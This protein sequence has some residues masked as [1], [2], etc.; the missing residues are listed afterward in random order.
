[1]LWSRLKPWLFWTSLAGGLGVGIFV[2]EA[3]LLAVFAYAFGGVL[4]AARLMPAF[5]LR[6]IEVSREVNADVVEIGDLVRVDVKVRNR[7]A[8]PILW[9]YVEELLGERFPVKGNVRRLIFIPPRRSFHLIYTLT[10]TRRGC[11][12]IGPLVLES[13]DVFG[14]FKKFRV[15]PRRDFVTVLP[16]YEVIE[17]FQV[18][19][20]RRLADMSVTRSLFED[21]SS[22]RGIRE[23][24]PGDA[25]KSIHWKSSAR[26]GELRTK[27]YDPVME[28]GATVVLDFHEESWTTPNYSDRSKDPAEMGIQIACTIAR[29]LWD[30]G[31][32]VGFFT[33]GRDPLGLGGLTMG[34]A[35]ATDSLSAALS[36]AREGKRDDRLAP[37]A[38]PARRSAEQFDVIRENLGRLRLSDGL[39]I[40]EALLAELPHIDRNQA[41]VYVTGDVTEEFTT[42]LQRVR[43]LGYRIMLFIVCN[44]EA[45]DRAFETL[46][47]MGV[48]V[49][50]MDLDWR[51]KEIAT[52]RQTF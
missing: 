11:H 46:F 42:A 36:A 27:L 18:G 29:Y 51:L 9:L 44:D 20:T 13:G 17:E 2:F 48:E 4:V 14:L 21:P 25:M 30:G 1:M 32:K 47:P 8:Y 10:M 50:R 45:H 16:R 19:T 28:A 26:T 39:R 23:Y 40:E 37:I 15:D 5:W 33:N 6:P 38:V 41:L 52:G 43:E 7:A 24:R 22:I 49:F 35:R 12:Q 34:E 31:W 3:G